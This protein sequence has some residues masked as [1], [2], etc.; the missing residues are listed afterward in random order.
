MAQI[1]SPDFIDVSNL[2]DAQ[3]RRLGHADEPDMPAEVRAALPHPMVAELTAAAARWDQR[4]DEFAR[5]KGDT[6]RDIA[7][8]L[9]R[10]GSFASEKQEQ[11]AQK[12]VAWSL[13]RAQEGPQNAPGAPGAPAAAPAV[14]TPAPAPAPV[15]RLEALHAVMQK[16][17]KFYVGGLTL[18]RKQGDQLVWIKH[19]DAEKVVGKIDNGVLTLWSRQG[20]DMDDV[21]DLLQELNADPLA[22][23]R[24][25]G[26]LSGRCCSCGADLVDPE[27]IER[28]Q[29]PVCAGKF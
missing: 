22:A 23:A 9:W 29:G 13:P 19:A 11:F 5:G 8:K 4:R 17:A 20:V 15:V 18:A 10:F 1:F 26:K 3:V 16:H 12:L 14:P 7:D 24:K 6:C 21:R 28:G 2:S 27:S 25:Y